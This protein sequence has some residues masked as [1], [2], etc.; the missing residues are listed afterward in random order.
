MWVMGCVT[1]RPTSCDFVFFLSVLVFYIYKFQ[2]LFH[3]NVSVKIILIR[4]STL[5]INMLKIKLPSGSKF[6]TNT[7]QPNN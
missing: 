1:Y 7:Y 2:E 3:Q 5:K 6:N 4:V